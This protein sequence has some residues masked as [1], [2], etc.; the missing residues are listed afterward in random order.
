MICR[1][2]LDVEG[3][4][5]FVPPLPVAEKGMSVLQAWGERVPRKSL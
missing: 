1:K 5:L 4:A 2:I 3:K